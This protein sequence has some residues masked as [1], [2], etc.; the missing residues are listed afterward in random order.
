M[1]PVLLQMLERSQGLR[2][3]MQEIE[4]GALSAEIL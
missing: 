3:V 4:L 1:T 2:E